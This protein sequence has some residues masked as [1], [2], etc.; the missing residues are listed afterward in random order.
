MDMDREKLQSML[1]PQLKELAKELGV[2]CS[3]CNKPVWIDRILAG[4]KAVDE[5]LP[6]LKKKKSR[7]PKRK[8]RS[9]KRK[10]R[11]PKRKSR[12]PKKKSKSPARDDERVDL[13]KF[14]KPDLER[15]AKEYGITNVRRK[16]K[17]ELLEE[18]LAVMPKVGRA[19]SPIEEEIYVSP[20]PPKKRTKKRTKKRSKKK[21][22]SRELSSDEEMIL[23]PIIKKRKKKRSKKKRSKSPSPSPLI[24][25]ASSGRT[26]PLI[27]GSPVPDQLCD[28]GGEH[29]CDD[30]NVCHLDQEDLLQSKCVPREDEVGIAVIG[31]HQVVGSVEAIKKLKSHLS[32]SDS[33]ES[34]GGEI[35]AED[36]PD[37]HTSDDE[38]ED[39]ELVGK[40]MRCLGLAPAG[41]ME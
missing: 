21:T 1:L 2:K 31:G 19:P 30:E 26:S 29:F 18:I 20:S 23:S 14:K 10:S 3:K 15:I 7:S 36:F 4:L 35:D 12:S 39:E 5:D 9:P 41:A 40:V 33:E 28:F 37:V 32:I 27:S 8:S 6:V 25:V 11:S 22:P 34:V 38:E 17:A 16:K 24:S 13:N